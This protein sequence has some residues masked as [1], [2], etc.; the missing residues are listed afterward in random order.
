MFLSNFLKH[1]NKEDGV[2]IAISAPAWF[3]GESYPDLFPTWDMVMFYKRTGNEKIYRELYYQDILAN[4]DPNKVVLD[5]TG[6]YI[7]C[8]EKKGE[9]CHRNLVAE[10]IFD[11]TGIKIIER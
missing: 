5:L 10:W 8:W 9:F 1:R 3:K 2:S 7:L 11:N 6:K 4:L